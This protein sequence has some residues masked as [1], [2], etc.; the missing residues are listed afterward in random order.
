M[1][2]IEFIRL[3]PQLRGKAM[4]IGQSFFASEEEAEDVAQETLIRLWKA[5][6][7]LTSA[8][9]AERLTVRVAKYECIN[10]WRREQSRPHTSLSSA[11]EVTHPMTQNGQP[12]EGDELSE[13]IRRAAGTLT[14]S[15]AR[16]WRLFAEAGMTAAEILNSYDEEQL[17]DILYIYGELKNARR[18]ASAIVKARNEK[19]IETTSDL[20]AATEK[21]F[22]RE[23]EKKEMAKMFQALR[24]EVNHE[25][26]ALKEMLNGARDVLGEGGRLSVIT[27]H[28]LEDRIVKNF[29]KAG[30][31]EGKVKQDFFGRI[32]APF[33][34]I[35]NKVIVP[36]DKE[37]QQ[38][39]R[40]RSAKLRI[41]ERV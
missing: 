15:E 40:S 36:T 14:K 35:N 2:Q 18:I 20:M 5:W 6:E 1:E 29:M 19:H 31:A 39:P 22:Q 33:K 23:R 38:N 12:M 28:S 8:E 16:L 9:E 4:A 37:Q 11:Q 41:A 3:A 34:S 27:Y 25:M 10:A 7:G 32:E 30:N 17:S 26:S 21:L 13:A 24:I